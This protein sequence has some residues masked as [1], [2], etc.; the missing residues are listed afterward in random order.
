MMPFDPEDQRALALAQSAM[1]R[2]DE[3]ARVAA[4][5]RAAARD[6]ARAVYRAIAELTTEVGRVNG[7]LQAVQHM[8]AKLVGEGS[9]PP[10][11]PL[12]A[13]GPVR[14]RAASINDVEA[15]LGKATE[16]ILEK[17]APHV[18]PS[19]RV[20]SIVEAERNKAI[21]ALI[22]KIVFV[23]LPLAGGLVLGHLA[24]K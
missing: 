20:R 3:A 4:E 19:Q 12:P 17:T 24:W 16:T 21:V 8:V 22:V 9:V 23:L 14:E 6:G 13:L 15:A 11:P 7:G 10:P 2:A 18:I 1:A 5:A